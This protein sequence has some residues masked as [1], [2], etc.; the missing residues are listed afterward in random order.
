MIGP[1]SFRRFWPAVGWFGPLAMG[2]PAHAFAA[3]VRA[4]LDAPETAWPTG[5]TRSPC[6][7]S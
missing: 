1:R 7:R 2:L 3:Q 4:I 6:R 5:S